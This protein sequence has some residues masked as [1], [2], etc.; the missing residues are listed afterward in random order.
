MDD[1]MLQGEIGGGATVTARAACGCEASD[2]F[3]P[4]LPPQLGPPAA[5]DQQ[6]VYRET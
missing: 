2:R 3:A 4:S 1:G 5:M 6:V